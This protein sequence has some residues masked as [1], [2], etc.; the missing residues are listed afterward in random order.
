[1]KIRI[2]HPDINK[3]CRALFSGMSCGGF[4]GTFRNLWLNYIFSC[5]RKNLSQNA[6]FSLILAE[7]SFCFTFNRLSNNR[8]TK[9]VVYK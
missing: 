5:N 1:M 4:C 2:F 6:T 9:F 8:I 7:I 3:F